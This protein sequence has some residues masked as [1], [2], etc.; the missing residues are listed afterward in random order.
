VY[1]KLVISSIWDHA[2]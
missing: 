2:I 1:Q